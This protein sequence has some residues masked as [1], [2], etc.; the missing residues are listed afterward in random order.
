MNPCCQ[1]PS[2]S[3]QRPAVAVCAHLRA[4]ATAGALTATV[5]AMTAEAGAATAKD[6]PT[7]MRMRAFVQDQ[8]TKQFCRGGCPLFERIRLSARGCACVCG[9][10]LG[11]NIDDQGA[12][13]DD[14]E[15][16]DH[17]Y[18]HVKADGHHGQMK[19]VL[20]GQGNVTEV[21]S[22]Q[23]HNHQTVA[24]R[25]QQGAMDADGHV[26]GGSC[27]EGHVQGRGGE[28]GDEQSEQGPGSGLD[29]YRSIAAH[30]GRGQQ[31]GAGAR[32]H[33]AGADVAD[34]VALS[35]IAEVADLGQHDVDSEEPPGEEGASQHEPPPEES[36]DHLSH[37]EPMP[38]SDDDVHGLVDAC[39]PRTES[40]NAVDL[41]GD[42]LGTCVRVGVRVG[43]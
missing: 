16:G 8:R 19:Q 15:G 2:V 7:S 3:C 6:V 17:K 1:L 23:A 31:D 35:N 18:A 20:Q 27:K 12:P 9:T 41:P 43:T 39:A 33:A 10:V 24:Q 13:G 28:N 25:E 36:I 38:V 21:L 22:S 37:A 26:Q 5:V 14:A 29:D 30:R 40:G 11:T 32:R 34:Q 4:G 42:S